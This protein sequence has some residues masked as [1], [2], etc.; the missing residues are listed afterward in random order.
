MRKSGLSLDECPKNEEEWKE[1]INLISNTYDEF[2]Q[3]RYL[4]ERSLELSSQEMHEKF[5]KNKQMSMQLVQA[6]KLS[7]LG[8]LS[9][10]IAHELNNPLTALLGFLEIMKKINLDETKRE[11]YIE[12]SLK[13]VN[14]MSSIVN[15]LRKLSRNT[16]GDDHTETDIVDTVIVI[17]SLLGKQLEFENIDY[18]FHFDPNEPFKVLG[19]SIRLESV[20]QNLI[21]NSKQAFENI[22]DDRNKSIKFDLRT[23]KS[24]DKLIITYEDNAGGM[25]NETLKRLFDPFF[26]TKEVGSGTGLGMSISKQII[27]EHLGEI[28]C[29]T[30]LGK[31]TKFKIVIPRLKDEQRQ[32]KAIRDYDTSG[33]FKI[34]DL[35]KKVLIVDNEPDICDI[36][37]FHLGDCFDIETTTDPMKAH[38][39]LRDNSYDLLITDIK[40]PEINGFELARLAR[41]TCPDLKIVFISGHIVGEL[42]DELKEFKDSILIQKPFL[43]FSEVEHRLLNFV[44]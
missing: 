39:A 16:E 24:L 5:E 14:R 43:N 42:S 22:N 10:G 19:D 34:K 17:F 32:V 26:T 41:E 28:S 27:E 23:N 8:T 25:E 2:E 20:F 7:S 21:I 29:E 4:L 9:S 6:N 18:T 13:L 33:F 12:R 35:K 3:D 44:S 30:Q 40:M 15:H 31:G 11:S 37:S 38:Q 1:F 36:T